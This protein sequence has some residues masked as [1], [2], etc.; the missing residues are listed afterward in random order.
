MIQPDF[1]FKQF[2]SYVWAEELIKILRAKPEL[3]EDKD[4]I[5]AWLANSYMKGYE[6]KNK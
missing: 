4:Y 3:V 2:D 5:A 6:A 1:L